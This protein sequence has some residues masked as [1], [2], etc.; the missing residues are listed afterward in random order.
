[1]NPK[2][3]V[4]LGLMGSVGDRFAT[5]GDKQSLA[6]LFELASRVEGL[7]GV[8]LVY[9]FNFPDV[10]EVKRLLEDHNLENSAVNVNV[11]ADPK[12]HRGSF[13]TIDSEVRA[14]AVHYLK[15]G[16]DL[17]A[18]LGSNLVTICPLADGH[19]YP[20][21]VDYGQVWRWLREGIGEAA[22]HRSDVTVSLEYK[23]SETRTHCVLNTAATSLHL[24]NQIGLPN[25]GVTIDLGHALYASEIPG[26]IVA[27]LDDADRLSLVHVNDNYREFDWDM[28]PGTV[29]LWDWLETFLYLDE[30]GYDGWFTSDVTPARL[31]PVRVADL[32]AKMVRDAW[33]FLEKI[34]PEE[35]RRLIKAG[36]SI[37]TLAYVQDRLLESS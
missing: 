6:D 18:D 13:T 10:E 9:P 29:N 36:D 25:L 19:D 16:M 33:R 34:G 26:Q 15:T 35:L 1:M 23:R 17:A 7:A 4:I 24:I 12:F 21:E 28:L 31:D 32:T 37:E 30:V 5:Y 2:F 22:S 11:K 27:L 3:S 8:E 20:F 14:E